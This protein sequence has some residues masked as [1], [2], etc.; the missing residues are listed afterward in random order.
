MSSLNLITHAV[1]DEIGLEGLDGITLESTEF[2]SFMRLARTVLLKSNFI[3]GLWKRVS[4]RLKLSFP[5]ADSFCVQLWT[6]IA[7][8][9][10]VAFYELAEPRELIKTFD[11]ADNTDIESMSDSTVCSFKKLNGTI[12][13]MT[14]F[15]N[16]KATQSTNTIR[17]LKRMVR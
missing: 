2:A 4:I 13:R 16:S 5:L 12:N 7:K 3:L 15:L 1:I 6:F 10:C 14:G 11:R 17:Y 9:K 8:Q